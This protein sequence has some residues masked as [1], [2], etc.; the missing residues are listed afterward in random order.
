MIKVEV[1]AHFLLQPSSLSEVYDMARTL[2]RAQLQVLNDTEGGEGFHFLRSDGSLPLENDFSFDGYSLINVP[3]PTLPNHIAN[4][5]YVDQFASTLDIKKSCRTITVT[6]ISDLGSEAPLVVDSVTLSA[7]DRVLVN[8]QTDPKQNGIY[9]VITVG[10]GSN[11]TWERADDADEDDEINAGLFTFVTEGNDHAD[12]GWVL[13]TDN[14]VEIGV[15]DIEF[16]QFTGVGDLIAGD[17]I[18]KIGDLIYFVAYDNSL[19]VASNG[20]RVNFNQDHFTLDVEGLSAKFNS[21]HFKVDEEEGLTLFNDNLDDGAIL[22]SQA[23]GTVNYQALS[24]DITLASDGTVEVLSNDSMIVSEGDGIRLARGDEG[25]V[26]IGQGLNND[27]QY[28]TATGDATVYFDGT[29]FVFRVSKGIPLDNYIVREVPTGNI[30]GSNTEFELAETPLSGSEMLFLNGHLQD[31]YDNQE[32]F[33]DYTINGASISFISA[34]QLND[35]LVANYL[36]PYEQADYEQAV[37]NMAGSDLNLYFPMNETEGSIMYD[38]S[39]N[40]SHGEY[41]NAILGEPSLVVGG[42]SAI[43]CEGGNI[44]Y[45]IPRTS[46]TN[47]VHQ[48]GSGA[49]MFY[50][51]QVSNPNAQTAIRPFISHAG[52]STSHGFDFSWDNRASFPLEAQKRLFLSIFRGTSSSSTWPLWGVSNDNAITTTDPYFIALTYQG[53][54]STVYVNGI[55]WGTITGSGTYSSSNHT[56]AAAQGTF[57]VEGSVQHLAHIQRVLT[58]QEIA[59]LY[60]LGI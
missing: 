12:S 14:P 39:G 31:R 37:I 54:S 46:F 32:E 51:L 2:V 47:A 15:H 52:T 24:G 30:D 50:W 7:G 53:A 44:A 45:T 57:G 49:T 4:K 5:A 27:P 16:T 41:V 55:F 22:I 17:G 33:G 18:D 3:E 19:I 43:R 48:D 29:S 28:K 6:N 26:I 58:P 35:T 36:I 60:T 21:E 34:P 59:D 56:L 1:A 8:G 40:D 38:H 25:Q 11:G 9:V 42:T 13:V 10:T 23:G 20:V